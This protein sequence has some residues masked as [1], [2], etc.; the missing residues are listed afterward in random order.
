MDSFVNFL[1]I[2]S[3]RKELPGAEVIVST[4]RKHENSEIILAATKLGYIDQLQLVEDVG[5][6]LL[7]KFE[8]KLNV[9]RQI[10]STKAGLGKAQRKYTLKLRS[11]IEIVN[12]N[13]VIHFYSHDARRSPYSIFKK[14]ILSPMIQHSRHGGW[15]Y[16]PSDWCYFGYTEDVIN[17]FNIDHNT[18]ENNRYMIYHTPSNPAT[19]QD[20]PQWK[21]DIHTQQYWSEQYIFVSCLLANNRA[22]PFQDWTDVTEESRNSSEMYLWHNFQVLDYGKMFG[23]RINKLSYDELCISKLMESSYTH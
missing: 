18:D 6:D 12:P 13:F 1:S 9:K 17:L 11:D 21:Q 15:L 14:R 4:E 20:L 19:Y 22:L 8:Y 23:I 7:P 16:F 10:F 3:V 2:Q 5:P